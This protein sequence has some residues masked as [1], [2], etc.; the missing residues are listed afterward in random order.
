MPQSKAREETLTGIINVKDGK[1]VVKYSSADDAIEI[2]GLQKP[3]IE[4]TYDRV[5]GPKSLVKIPVSNGKL[6]NRPERSL[7]DSYDVIC[8]IDTN[9]R[10]VRQKRI[11]VTG[12]V[13]C[14]KCWIGDPHGL[15]RGWLYHTPFCIEII[16]LSEAKAENAGWSFALS[17]LES[18]DYIRRDER[19][20]IVVDSDLGNLT[21]Y[22]ER[23][24]RYDSF[25]LLPLNWRFIYGS[26]DIGA[27]TLVNLSIKTAD[28]AAKQ[29]LRY[30]ESGNQMLA[31]RGGNLPHFEAIAVIW[32]ATPRIRRSR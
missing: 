26:S 10:L 21:A 31:T 2:E 16:E 19:V 23:R 28:N 29:C 27:E 13:I 20:G 6:F 1:I 8:A 32:P 24:E 11:S 15:T 4:R 22:N 7:D 30:L 9:T 5:K 3:Y 14:E 12:I 25:N 18:L 17:H